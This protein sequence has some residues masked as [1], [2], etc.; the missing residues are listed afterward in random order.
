MKRKLNTPVLTAVAVT[1]ICVLILSC[2][3]QN[4]PYRVAGKIFDATGVKGGL[5]VHVGCGNGK[6]TAALRANDSYLVHGLDTNAAN[7]EQARNHIKTLGLYGKVS[8]DTFDGERLPYIDNLV[9]LVI[10]E[11]PGR[12]S[13]NEII[14]VLCPNGVA[15]VRKNGKWEKTVKPWPEEIDEWTHFLHDPSNNAVAHDSVIGPPR[16][17]QWIGS[18]RWARHHDRM[19]SMSALVSAAGRIFYIFDEGSTSSVILQPKWKLIA[20]DAFNGTILWKRP[21]KNWH[22]H[23]WPFKSGPAY[24]PRRLVADSDVVYVTL[25]LTAPLTALD[26][27][28]GETIRMYDGSTATEEIITSDGV[29]F[30]VV[31][32]SPRDFKDFKPIHDNVGAE[33][34]RV[35]EVWAWDKKMRWVKAVRA[36]TGKELW[37]AEHPVVHLTLAADNEHVYFYDG[38]KIVCLDRQNGKKLWNSSP[39][40]RRPIIPVS[41]APTLVVYED[42]VLF[43]GGLRSMTGVSAR[44]GETLWTSDY[45]PVGHHSPEDILVAG[46]LVWAGAT[47]LTKDSGVFTGRDSK[48]G[49]IIS[50]FPPDVESYWFHQRCYRAKATDRYLLPS[51]TGIEFIDHKN[52]HWTIHHWVRGGCIY[53]IMPCNGLIYAPMHDCACYPEAKL[54]GFCA[55]APESTLEN[56]NK[57][58]DEDRLEGGPAYG[59]KIESASSPDAND[60]PTYRHDSFRS[61]YIKMPVPADLS[62]VWQTD[63]G[64]RLSSV[65]IAGGKVY[66]ASVDNH[67]VY[68]VDAENGDI[69]WSFTAGGRVDSPPTVWKGRVLFGSADGRVYCLR[70]SDGELIWSFRAAPVDFRHTVFE[71]V[72]SVWPVHGS[73]LVQDDVV[74][75]VAGRSMFVDGGLRFLKLDPVTGKKLSEVVLDDRDPETGDNLQVRVSILNM[76]VALPDILSSDGR[77][78]Y[79]KSQ[80]FDFD[81]NRLEVGPHG[82]DPYEQGSVQKGEGVH[83]FCPTGFLDDTWFHRTYWVYGRSFAGGWGGYYQAGKYA[84]G[85][86]ILVFDDTRVYG[87]GRLPQYYRWTTA[88]E[89]HLFACAKQPEIVPM[90][91]AD[92]DKLPIRRQM[93]PEY[94]WSGAVPLF[95]RAMV[96]TGETLFIA[97]PPDIVD[98]EEAFDRAYEIAMIAELDDQTDALEG[99]KGA[100]IRVISAPNGKI[101]AEFTFESSPVFD[102]MA[103]AGG[104]LYMALENGSLVCMG[105]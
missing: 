56:I 14:R 71:Q 95:A 62:Q 93:H 86:R 2:A 87:F 61:G 77:Y 52:K 12:L 91:E 26:A 8:V 32:E 68:S 67:T 54:Y 23:L 84:P 66:V 105:K 70:A 85:G 5:I 101:L 21:I 78:I 92:R 64:G 82:G 34:D 99:R 37:S 31:N 69:I 47:A 74:Y 76:P 6:L 96:L 11:N 53:G 13:M 79:M 90:T 18:P 17:L 73:V 40:G 103:S 46:G 57:L 35:A 80:K 43:S 36:D 83:L 94:V 22:P 49:E 33:R 42:V 4:T 10:A 45:P 59:E 102:G 60:W 65:V 55:L 104:R 50:Q 51:R 75:C 7:V 19:G 24:L 15:Y 9:N 98:E 30:L 16:R 72:E 100:L 88:L 1:V 44:T 20:R 38:E 39:V 25:G 28:T 97:G 27:A 3:G 63:I 29:L 58:S 89:H 41:F 48:T 81:G